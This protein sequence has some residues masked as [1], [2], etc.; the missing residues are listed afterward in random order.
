MAAASVESQSK[1]DMVLNISETQLAVQEIRETQLAGREDFGVGDD[2]LMTMDP[3]LDQAPPPPYQEHNDFYQS[4]PSA[5]TH[6]MRTFLPSTNVLPSSICSPPPSY[7]QIDLSNHHLP[8]ATP[9]PPSQ[10][11]G[12][13]S[14]DP[15]QLGPGGTTSNLGGARPKK[16]QQANQQ[17]TNKRMIAASRQAGVTSGQRI[18]YPWLQMV[19]NGQRILNVR[20]K[21]EEE[22]EEMSGKGKAAEVIG[23]FTIFFFFLY[24]ILPYTPFSPW[25]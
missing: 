7:S 18:G 1:N 4:H 2:I 16:L 25:D 21:Q 11:G 3:M 22:E 17:P 5:P 10:L 9:H 20:P 12:P 23:I 15:S 13:S 24:L 19:G 6:P 14:Y 8:Y